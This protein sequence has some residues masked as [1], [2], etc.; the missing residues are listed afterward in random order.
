M[1]LLSRFMGC[2]G[3]L[4]GIGSEHWIRDCRARQ[5][6]RIEVGELI[7]ERFFEEG[8]GEARREMKVCGD[9]RWMSSA[10][11]ELRSMIFGA[12]APQRNISVANAPEAVVLSKLMQLA[13]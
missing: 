13:L 2:W 6:E 1:G 9:C 4:V 12:G 7:A 10:I 5:L 8:G 11:G 3:V